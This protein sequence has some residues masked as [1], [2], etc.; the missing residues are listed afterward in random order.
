MTGCVYGPFRHIGSARLLHG[1]TGEVVGRH[2]IATGWYRVRLDTNE[3]TPHALWYVPGDRLVRIDDPPEA[4]CEQSSLL[5]GIT[6][7]DHFP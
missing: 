2:P 5:P 1:L 6:T 4:D 7:V 3:V